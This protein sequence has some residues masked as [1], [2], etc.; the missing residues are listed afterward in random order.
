MGLPIPAALVAHITPQSRFDF[1]HTLST[2]ACGKRPIL[3]T[4]PTDSV[5]QEISTPKHFMHMNPHSFS[6]AGSSGLVQAAVGV[7]GLSPVLHIVYPH[8]LQQL[9]YNF[10]IALSNWNSYV[11]F[12][13][14]NR[15]RNPALLDPSTIACASFLALHPPDPS[16]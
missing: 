14:E 1:V 6:T 8:I 16:M 13:T 5:G 9:M 12:P 7:V 10:A 15:Q 4:D 11:A 2:N 3:H